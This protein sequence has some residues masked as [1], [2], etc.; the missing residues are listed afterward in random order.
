[1]TPSEEIHPAG[2]GREDGSR[3]RHG[4]ILFA[5]VAG[6]LALK[7]ALLS[8]VSDARP[9]YDE[10]G[11]LRLARGIE[12]G[13]GLPGSL[14]PPVY[15]HVLALAMASAPEGTPWR[16]SAG[17]LQILVSG[18]TTI[19]LYQLAADLFGGRSGL[20]A[21]GIFAFYPEFV[22]YTHVLLSETLVLL[23][24][25]AGLLL[26]ER[27]R[28]RTSSRLALAA[29]ALI[30]VGGLTRE[31]IFW[32]APVA[33]LW[34]ALAVHRGRRGLSLAVLA[35]AF[36][37]VFPW[38]VRNARVHGALVLISTNTA[39]PLYLANNDREPS[40]PAWR[41]YD[42]WGS[43]EVERERFAR[44]EAIRFILAHQPGWGLER[45]R[46]G[47]PALL[48]LDNFPLQHLRHGWYGPAAPAIRRGVAIVSVFC[49]L[50]L[51]VA[52]A[53]GLAATRWT[54]GRF[55]LLLFILYGAAVVM[56]AQVVHRY[57]LPLEAVAIPFAAAWLAR[58]GGTPGL[59][60]RPYYRLVAASAAALALCA[61]ALWDARSVLAPL[62]Q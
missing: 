2:G 45:L 1:M 54:P 47:V 13:L 33:A 16:V 56:P 50:G 17:V 44:H 31:P 57:R 28:R 20:L 41:F 19:L 9:G 42:G 5:I 48:S 27:A 29:G 7:L 12:K 30:G 14:R 53:F 10:F 38:T 62:L 52:S 8:L 4:L 3:S 11:Y 36:L 46:V 40:G 6:S 34:I 60:A 24:L 61:I 59:L 58:S 55:L 15:P 22:A 18:A 37:V 32:F 51:L 39:T 35:G 49:Y 26:L 21:A 23:P 43:R 25:V